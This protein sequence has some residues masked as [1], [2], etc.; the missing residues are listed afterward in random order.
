MDS[1]QQ[2][3]AILG[4]GVVGIELGKGFAANGWRVVY[5]TRDVNGAKT[6]QALAAVPGAQAASF[7]EAARAAAIAVVALPWSGQREGIAVSIGHELRPHHRD[8]S[9]TG[10]L[11]RLDAAVPGHDHVV[12]I[13]DDRNE[14]A[15]ALNAAGNQ[16]D[17]LVGMDARVLGIGCH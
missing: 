16:R 6:K 9:Q 14:K 12:L 7:D 10:Q 11:G 3:V 5:G 13:N 2:T 1:N 8:F 4:N 17:L 15:I